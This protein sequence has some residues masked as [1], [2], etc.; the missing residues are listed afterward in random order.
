MALIAAGLSGADTSSA[1]IT[2][3]PAPEPNLGPDTGLASSQGQS[4]TLLPNAAGVYLWSDGSTG[5]SLTVNSTNMAPG[6]YTY[7]V[8]VTGANGCVGTDTIQIQV[9]VFLSADDAW[10]LPA[11]SLQPNPA[12]D[13]VRLSFVSPPSPASVFEVRLL[14]LTGRVLTQRVWKGSEELTLGLQNLARGL[15]LISVE[16]EGSSK[17]MKVVKE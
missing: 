12:S 11:L 5:S 3:N 10:K 1:T 2:V 17:V 7:W 16:G 6:T 15:Y 9:A 13:A 14:D 4:I 8:K